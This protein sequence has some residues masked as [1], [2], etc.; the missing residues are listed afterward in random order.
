MRS[1]LILIS[2][3]VFAFAKA[4]SQEPIATDSTTIKKTEVAPMLEK[5][6]PADAVKEFFKYF[7][8]KDTTAMREMMVDGASLNTLVVSQ[9][10]GKKMLHTPINEFLKGIAQIPDSVSFEE[11]LIQIRVTNSDDIASVNTTYEFYMNDGFTHNGVN[12]FTM[13]YIDDK[14]KIT[15]I[16]DTRQYP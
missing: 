13:V 2:F 4:Y 11:Q 5:Q 14:W 16:A 3:M 9:S 7:H 15:S 12:V 10:K 1:T 6:K 8:A